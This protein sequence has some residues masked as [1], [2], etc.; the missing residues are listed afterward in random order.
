ME[1]ITQLHQQLLDVSNRLEKST[2]RLHN[3]QQRLKQ[4]QTNKKNEQKYADKIQME[5]AQLTNQVHQVDQ[6]LDQQMTVNDQKRNDR[7]MLLSQNE[8]FSSI[9]CSM[10]R[11]FQTKSEAL[12]NRVTKETKQAVDLIHGKNNS[13]Y[14]NFSNSSNNSHIHNPH[15]IS[16]RSLSDGELRQLENRLTELRT[17]IDCID[18]QARYLHSQTVMYRNEV[19]RLHQHHNNHSSL[20][21]SIEIQTTTTNIIYTQEWYTEIT[22]ERMP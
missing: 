5:I 15:Q 16:S 8:M 6:A 1:T 13:T 4:L 22:S 7:D 18:S 3:E 17:N 10:E 21:A 12:H 20:P 9:L 11:D 2:S 14:F 19:Q